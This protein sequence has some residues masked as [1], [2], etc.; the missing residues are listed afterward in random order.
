M[1]ILS[2]IINGAGAGA[3]VTLTTSITADYTI[4]STDQIIEVDATSGNID[5]TLPTITAAFKNK[6]IILIKRTDT[7]MNT[8]TIN[9]T[10]GNFEDE[11]Y[12]LGNDPQLEVYRIYAS[13]DNIWRTV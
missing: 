9:G 10:G 3:G 7:S 6:G 12:I 8:V 5:L 4:I 2:N 13:N 11:G 1:T